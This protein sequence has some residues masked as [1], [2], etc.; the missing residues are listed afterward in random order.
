MPDSR[1]SR[2]S[3]RPIGP[4][5]RPSRWPR[6]APAGIARRLSRTDALRT[7]SRCAM[8]PPPTPV[9]RATDAH[10]VIA[11]P[12]GLPSADA[13][14]AIVEGALLA[15]YRLRRPAQRAHRHAAHR[16]DDR[17]AGGR[18]GRCASGAPPAVGARRRHGP[19]AGP[20]QHAPQ[21][22][23]RDAPGRDRRRAWARDAGLDVEVVD[24]A[25]AAGAAPRRPAGGQPGQRGAAGDDQADLPPGGRRV[26]PGRSR[27][28]RSWARG[29]CTTRAASPSSPATRSTPR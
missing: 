21:P 19:R 17:R 13:A 2:P 24:K 11:L 18:P 20:R 16:P 5:A 10:L 26:A 3:P 6:L 27:T 25:G 9:S 4:V 28:S 15:R 1:P 22:P 23:L 14:A 29:S 12:A 8:P 7:R